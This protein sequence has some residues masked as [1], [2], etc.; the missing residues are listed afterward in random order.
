MLFRSVGN[1]E[2][3]GVGTPT[4]VLDK[5]RAVTESFPAE[6]SLTFRN[7]SIPG[8]VLLCTGLKLEDGSDFIDITVD[9]WKSIGK[10][11]T[12]PTAVM[13][14]EEVLCC[15]NDYNLNGT[16][17]IPAHWSMQKCIEWLNKYPITRTEEIEYL[18]GKIEWY[19]RA[20]IE[21]KK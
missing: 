14:K 15:F 6:I 4:E 21:S 11:L 16:R 8:L 10:K 2:L 13:Y 17:P 20:K 19:K 1:S 12:K 3:A 9:P 5:S 18:K 7:N